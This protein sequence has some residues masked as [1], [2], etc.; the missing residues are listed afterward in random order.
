MKFLFVCITL[1]A[2]NSSAPK[3]SPSERPEV[4][5][6][7]TTYNKKS[8]KGLRYNRPHALL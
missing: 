1:I 7:P 6:L 2:D 4:G 8:L 3:V 5:N